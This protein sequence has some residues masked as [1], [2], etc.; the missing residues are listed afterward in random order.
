MENGSKFATWLSL[1]LISTLRLNILRINFLQCIS[2]CTP[3]SAS[4]FQRRSVVCA[5][6]NEAKP[7][8]KCLGAPEP[9]A[10]R[11]CDAICDTI[12]VTTSSPALTVGM[13]SALT[14]IGDCLSWFK[15]M[16]LV[17]YTMLARKL[18]FNYLYLPFKSNTK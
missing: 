6:A 7:S 10:K 18:L 11:S 16:F 2:N 4:G 3:N 1:D 15:K 9:P 13:Y 8:V 5:I 17:F 14:F 12:V